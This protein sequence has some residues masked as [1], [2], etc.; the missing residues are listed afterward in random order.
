MSGQSQKFWNFSIEFYSSPAVAEACL[1]LQDR[2]N[3]DVNLLLFCFWY[4]RDYGKFQQDILQ[5]VSE[6]SKKWKCNVVQPMRSA[7]RWMKTNASSLLSGQSEEYSALREGIKEYELQAE[8][9]QQ[10]SMEKIV[11][12]SNPVPSAETGRHL[13]LDNLHM[14]F[15]VHSIANEIRNDQQLARLI[16]AYELTTD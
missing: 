14:L 5:S 1:E 10:L 3:L 12:E 8:K 6:F 15:E 9:F 7:R 4:S 11:R 13:L 2:Y 16:E